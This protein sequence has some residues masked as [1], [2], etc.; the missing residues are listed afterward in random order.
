MRPRILAQ[1]A[2]IQGQS[3]STSVPDS[4][5]GN[6]GPKIQHW[7]LREGKERTW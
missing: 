7:P 3:G 4:A 6:G 2:R 5:A 1:A